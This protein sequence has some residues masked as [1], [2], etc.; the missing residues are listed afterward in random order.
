M[1]LL[2]FHCFGLTYFSKTYHFGLNYLGIKNNYITFIQNNAV[3]YRTIRQLPIYIF[4]NTEFP[5]REEQTHLSDKK[6]QHKIKNNTTVF[7]FQ[8]QHSSLSRCTWRE[9]SC[10]ANK[11]LFFVFLLSSY[12]F[13]FTCFSLI[14]ILK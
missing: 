5:L 3:F 1:V 4:P 2:D 14:F 6:Q 10:Y 9:N 7:K 11:L 12:F 8:K 13:I